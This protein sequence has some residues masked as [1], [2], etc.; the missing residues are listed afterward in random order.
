MN[1]VRDQLLARARLAAD[2]DGRVR[3]GHLRDL[4]VHLPHRSARPDD[5]R[6]VVA[7]AELLPQV[8]VFV[9]EPAAILLDQ[10]LNLD[11]LRQHRGDDPEKLPRPIEVAV[12]LELEVDRQGANRLAVQGDRHADEAQFLLGQLGAL[13]GA[14]QQH[15]LAAGARHDHRPAGFDD[16]PRN[17]LA[18]PV[19]H[20]R[21][22][23]FQA[24]RTLRRGARRPRASSVTM[25]R[26]AP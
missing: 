17:A 18:D 26:T 23:L 4:L 5:V 22:R 14:V 12:R 3:A 24:V 15:R 19:F 25:P 8:R 2:E 11:R 21:A 7:L 20:R 10:P 9:L 1:R 13:R 16:A 6:E